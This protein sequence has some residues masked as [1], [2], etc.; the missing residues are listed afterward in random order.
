MQTA[1]KKELLGHKGTLI[2]RDTSN[3]ATLDYNSL[4]LQLTTGTM[5]TK[6]KYPFCLFNIKED[7]ARVIWEVTNACNYTCSYCIFSSKWGN[8]Q[9]DLSTENM[10]RALDDLWAK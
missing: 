10:K 6:K 4:Y 9:Y 8:D 5:S 1:E 7:G 3:D 2:V